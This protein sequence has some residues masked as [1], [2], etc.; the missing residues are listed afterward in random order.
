MYYV[1]G[2]NVKDKNHKKNITLKKTAGS[3]RFFIFQSLEELLGGIFSVEGKGG[4]GGVGSN[5]TI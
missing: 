4:R 3:V 1:F 2:F 5:N